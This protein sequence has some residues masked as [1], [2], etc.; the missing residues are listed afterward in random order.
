MWS[1]TR[2]R[3]APARALAALAALLF[4]GCGR[5]GAEPPRREAPAAPAAGPEAPP[6]RA[7]FFGSSTTAGSG[8]SRRERRWTSIVSRRLGWIEVNRGLS[9]S[10]LTAVRGRGPSGEERWREAVA[11]ARPDVVVL[12]YGA[13][14]VL[15]RVPLGDP[16]SPG[17]F[18]HAAAAVLGGLR[19]A[20]PEATIVVC[21]PQPSPAL[22]GGRE[23]YDLALAEGAARV[24]AIFV[25]AGA[26]FPEGLAGAVQAD[27]L[28]LTDAG[29]AALAELVVA[30]LE[31]RRA[32]GPPR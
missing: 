19:A 5:P 13:N 14:D 7:V 9:S 6:L 11:A 4:A 27:R 18:R 32:P 29:H 8:A 16:G 31:G 2:H 1:P 25:S 21:T 20:L 17:T 30:R 10:T 15:A 12:M 28:H 22:A 23:R 3:R 26:A 24:G